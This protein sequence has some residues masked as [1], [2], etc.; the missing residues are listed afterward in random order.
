MMKDSLINLYINISKLYLL[1][2]LSVLI[3]GS[4]NGT[5]SHPSIMEA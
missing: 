1:I 5:I 3:S 4:K 2:K